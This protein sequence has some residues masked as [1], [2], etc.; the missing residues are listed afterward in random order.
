MLMGDMLRDLPGL[1]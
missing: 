1:W